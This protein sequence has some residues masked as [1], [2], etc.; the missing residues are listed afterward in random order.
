MNAGPGAGPNYDN[1]STKCSSWTMSYY[2]FGYSAVSIQIESA[3]DNNGGPGAW[4]IVSSPAPTT[5]TNPLTSTSGGTVTISGFYAPWIRVNLTV[6]TGTGF[7]NFSI[8]GTNLVSKST[9]GGGGG[10]DTITSPNGTLSVGGTST[11][12]TLDVKN[13]QTTVNGQVCSLGGSCTIS[14]GGDT[15]TSPNGTLTVGGTSSNTT[16]DVANPETTVNG[17]TCTLGSTCTVTAAPS[18][19]AGGSLTGSY[20]NPT[21][22][23]GA[24]SNA[25]LANPATTVNGQTCTLGSTCTVAIGSVVGYVGASLVNTIAASTTTYN[26]FYSSS[27]STT[28]SLRAGALGT[29][30]VAQN[31]TL[32]VI[33]GTQSTNSLVITLRQNLATPS[34]GPAITIPAGGTVGVFQDTTHTLSLAATDKIDFQFVNNSASTSVDIGLIGFVCK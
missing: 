32:T 25:D 29:A 23:S 13:P 22:A 30:C 24:V 8:E 11:N 31:F 3:P 10:G 5:G 19:S 9:S 15:I 16:L 2:S 20:P 17:Q 34:N 33:N 6:A 18:G 27:L 7:V 4:S 14:A 26:S 12:T 28:E 21:I 1:R